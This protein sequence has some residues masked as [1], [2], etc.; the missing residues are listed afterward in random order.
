MV[1]LLRDI[2]QDTKTFT[3]NITASAIKEMCESRNMIDKIKK[4]N[5]LFIKNINDSE[6]M[7]FAEKVASK[8]L[9]ENSISSMKTNEETSLFDS[10]TDGEI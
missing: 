8:L 3:S 4:P 6:I 9:H 10:T 7:N 5:V 2:Y 1:N